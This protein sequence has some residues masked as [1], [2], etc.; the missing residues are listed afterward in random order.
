MCTFGLSDCHVKPRRLWD[1]RGFTQTC[2]FQA[3]ALQNPKF[4]EE[5]SQERER[6][7]RMKHVEGEEKKRN[8]GPPTFR[9]LH[10][11]GSLFLGFGCPAF[12]APTLRGVLLWLFFFGI[13]LFCF[14]EKEDQ[15][16]ETPILAKVSLAKLG[17][18]PSD[19]PADP[20]AP[21]PLALDRLM[22][23][24]AKPTLA[25]INLTNL[26]SPITNFGQFQCFSLLAFF[27]KKTTR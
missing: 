6:E 15:K 23:T 19:P 1:R 2:T 7:E 18:S 5:D 4:H 22:P 8:F 14:S 26:N 13:L 16:T 25:N 27:V 11:R 10:L 9:G 21:D 17:L 24:L 3:P 20:P 12:R